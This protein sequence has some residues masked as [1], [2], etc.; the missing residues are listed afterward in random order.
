MIKASL[1][2][3]VECINYKKV[4]MSISLYI[5]KDCLEKRL[6]FESNRLEELPEFKR[7]LYIFSKE[8][9]YRTIINV[10]SG[11]YLLRSSNSEAI[12]EIIKSN[13]NNNTRIVVYQAEK[14]KLKIKL[15]IGKDNDANCKSCYFFNKSENICLLYDKPNP[16][17]VCD[18]Y[19]FYKPII[20]GPDLSRIIKEI[21]SLAK[22]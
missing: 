22:K 13:L 20:S 11:F 7:A 3:I 15:K 21:Y 8:N 14:E 12:N 1:D 10:K 5:P 16:E 2:A 6:G 9:G 19:T 4:G 17:K 18:F